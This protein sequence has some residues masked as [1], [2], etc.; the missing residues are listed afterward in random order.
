METIFRD[1]VV[2]VTGA[3]GSV[4]QELVRQ[5]ILLDPA[6]I[7]LVDNNESELF[8]MSEGLR[9]HDNVTAYL[10]DVRDY[11][12]VSAVA[13]SSDIILH[14]AA[15]KHVF[16]S[17]YNP[18]EAVQTNILGVKNVI[19]AAVGNGTKLVIFTSS[20]KAVNPTSVMG[21]SKLMGERLITAANA[22]RHNPHQRFSSVRFGNVVGSRGSVFQ[23]FA[24]QIKQG[25]PVTVTDSRMT[26]FI[27]SLERA[28]Q[29]VLEGAVLARGGEVL[30]TKMQVISI[31]DLAQ[32]LIELLAP[33]YGHDPNSMSIKL[34]G[35]KPGEKMYEELISSEEMGRCLELE[36]MFVVLPAFRSIYHDIDYTFA[37]ATGH[38]LT[39]PY[40]SSQ[41]LAMSKEEIKAF[42]CNN[43]LLPED[44]SPSVGMG[45]AAC[46]S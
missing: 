38:P 32:V 11:Q 12:K 33:Y 35:A 44:L 36:D 20:D 7:R 15:F 18:F 24:D 41:G 10:G 31:M 30:V 46:V 9:H 1:Q 5:L 17:E 22:V 42:L 43:R 28:A 39:H 21:T 23:I 14:C 25:G 34:I 4:G 26:R 3:A 29:L 45:M 16:F 2:M 37:G 27:M 6:E 8:L 19:E 40:N 13:R